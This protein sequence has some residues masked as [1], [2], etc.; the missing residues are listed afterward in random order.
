[1]GK[2]NLEL[3]SILNN[4]VTRLEETDKETNSR[5]EKLEKSINERFE[6]TEKKIDEG[7]NKIMTAISALQS[8][9]NEGKGKEKEPAEIQPLEKDNTLFLLS[10][11]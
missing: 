2:T 3:E 6:K 1:V 9:N 5:I 8:K 10:Q 4:A 11:A 7:F